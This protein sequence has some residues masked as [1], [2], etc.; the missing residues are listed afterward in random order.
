MARSREGGTKRGTSHAAYAQ[1]FLSFVLSS[2]AATPSAREFTN[3][4][5]PPTLP[6]PLRRKRPRDLNVGRDSILGEG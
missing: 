1:T 5:T 4:L 3:N 2:D 6:R